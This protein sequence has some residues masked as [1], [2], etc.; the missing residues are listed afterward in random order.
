MT[1][2]EMMHYLYIAFSQDMSGRP[3]RL[4]RKQLRGIGSAP[5]ADFDVLRLAMFQWLPLSKLRAVCDSFCVE[6]D[7]VAIESNIMALPEHVGYSFNAQTP[8]GWNI[9]DVHF[10][11]IVDWSGHTVSAFQQPTLNRLGAPTQRP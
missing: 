6:L 2:S 4:Y 9:F 11:A 7:D 1:P 3:L 5:S 8:Q 10:P